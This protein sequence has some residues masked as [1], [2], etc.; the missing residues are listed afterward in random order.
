[1]A[2]ML[3]KESDIYDHRC[4]KSTKMPTRHR[5]IAIWYQIAYIRKDCKNRVYIT[6]IY[7]LFVYAHKHYS[8]L[9]TF[10]ERKHFAHT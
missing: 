6:R 9:V 1:M 4:K 5:K 8:A 3:E 10:P 2:S 7:T